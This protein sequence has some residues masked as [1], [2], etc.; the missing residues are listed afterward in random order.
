MPDLE[1]VTLYADG[2]HTIPK[3]QKSLPTSLVF[4]KHSYPRG[5]KIR[6]WIYCNIINLTAK[7]LNLLNKRTIGTPDNYSL[8]V[9]LNKC[10]Q[11]SPQQMQLNLL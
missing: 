3:Q 7:Q 6:V 2:I 4:K 9:H 8:T 1:L 10:M 5:F 11:Y